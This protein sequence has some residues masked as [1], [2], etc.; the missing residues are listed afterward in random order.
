ML[1]EKGIKRRLG[2]C[3][4]HHDRALIVKRTRHRR[5]DTPGTTG[6]DNSFCVESVGHCCV[7]VCGR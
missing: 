5:T 4:D 3:P 1:L 6:D 2:F 7:P